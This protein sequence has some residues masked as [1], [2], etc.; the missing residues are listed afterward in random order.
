MALMAVPVLV[1]VEAGLPRL[2]AAGMGLYLLCSYMGAV[3][4]SLSAGLL[5]ERLGAIRASQWALML[6]ALGLLLAALWPGALMLAAVLIGLGY[7]PITPASSHVLIH[8]TPARQRNLVFSIK[9]TGVPLGVALCG[10][11]VPPLASATGWVGTLLVLALACALVAASAYP[12]QAEMDAQTASVAPGTAAALSLRSALARL[13]EPFAVIWRHKPL[14]SL[15][16]VSFV[17][18]GIQ[19]S[20]TAYLV[21][22]L[23]TSLGLAALLAGS[24]LALSQLGGVVGR[25][26]W[27]YVADRLL[28]PLTT[29]ALL[30][31][32]T[33]LASLTT[34]SLGAWPIAPPGLLLACLMFIFGATASGWNGV[35]LAE[36]ARQAPAGLVGMATSGTLACTFLGVLLGAPLF[37]LVVSSRGGYA[38]AFSLEALLAL[39]AALLLMTFRQRVV[40]NR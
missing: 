2:S 26:A 36:V 21:S 10:V 24:V 7:G 33:A 12:I 29:L 13:L 27:G 20:F 38:A 22:Y 18:S 34:A 8:T 37:G 15:A 23:T 16:A 30:V 28:R 19:I 6:S 31:T 5:I 17:L 9:Q 14:R 25:I 3:L 35:Y 32:V 39:G 4:G 40:N 11:C 1:P